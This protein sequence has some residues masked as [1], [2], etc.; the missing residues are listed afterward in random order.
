MVDKEDSIQKTW[1]STKVVCIVE[2]TIYTVFR[3]INEQIN[4]IEW[5]I[6]DSLGKIVLWGDAPLWRMEKS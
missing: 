5:P 1:E 3:S 4:I 6:K 2:G